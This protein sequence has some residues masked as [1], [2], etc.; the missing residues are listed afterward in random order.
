MRKLWALIFL[1]ALGSC[2][3]YY[4]A[5]LDERYGAADPARYDRP[6]PSSA[7]V[8]YEREVK[9]ILDGRCAVC[10]GCR[11]GGLGMSSA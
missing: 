9:P 3:V 2:A 1:F 8:D 11:L 10:H 5:R 6:A 7:S 4:G